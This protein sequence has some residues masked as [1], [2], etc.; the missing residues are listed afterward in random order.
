MEISLRA[1]EPEDLDILY[2][3]END[4]SLWG[5]GLTNVPYSRYV[6]HEYIA[7]ASGDI[8]TDKQV[9]LMIVRGDD[10]IGMVDIVNF[11]PSHRR[12]EVGIVIR[13]E[14]RRRGY[15]HAA[16]REVITY[17]RDILHL[18]QLYALAEASNTAALRLFETAGFGQKHLLKNWLYNG[19]QYHD[20][21]FYQIFF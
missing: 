1:I 17:A 19:R 4:T 11:S 6:L 14:H 20:A 18:H 10:V 3:I 16:L 15:A 13:R 2:R 5:V 8:Y 12:A 9:R 21:F 7:E